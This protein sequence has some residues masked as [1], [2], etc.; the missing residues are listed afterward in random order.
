MSS[1]DFL[2]KKPLLDSKNEI[3]SIDDEN[4]DPNLIPNKQMN[5]HGDVELT[6]VI[7]LK[8]KLTIA[9]EVTEEPAESCESIVVDR[10]NEQLIREFCKVSTSSL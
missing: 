3:V 9:C 7:S 10:S 1:D 8:P 5:S 6:S 4:I 2:L